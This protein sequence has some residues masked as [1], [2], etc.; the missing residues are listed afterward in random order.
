[1]R[2]GAPWHIVEGT[3]D[4][5]RRATVLSLVRNALTEHLKS[6]RKQRKENKKARD[7]KLDDMTTEVRIPVD[8]M[9]RAYQ[10][11]I[12]NASEK[13]AAGPSTSVGE[14]AVELSCAGA[15][16][17]TWPVLISAVNS[18]IGSCWA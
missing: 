18:L 9:R 6:R 15:G 2:P 12:A 4:T 7:P 10:L 14:T 16:G 1:M 5:F 11:F 13:A 3:D 17:V 8:E